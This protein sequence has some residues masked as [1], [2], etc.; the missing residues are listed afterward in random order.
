MSIYGTEYTRAVYLKKAGYNS[1]RWVIT[2]LLYQLYRENR[3]KFI[4]KVFKKKSAKP[5]MKYR[6][7]EIIT[8]ILKNL[9]PQ[10]TLEWGAGYSTLYFSQFAG[11]DAKWFSIEHHGDW[12]QRVKAMNTNLNMEIFYVE[13]DHFPWTDEFNDGSYSDLK[14]YIDFADGLGDF[15]FI[16]I[17]GRARKEALRKAFQLI[18]DDGVVVL[19]DANRHYYHEPF[20]LFNHQALFADKRGDGGGIWVGSK[21]REINSVLDLAL[22][23]KLWRIYNMFQKD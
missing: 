7:I 9:K 11:K 23:A 3:D 1:K 6:E 10:R 18:K 19:H 14:Q 5:L 2:A 8:E 20:K 22:Y 12:A 15:D 17:D 13:P 16:F 21:G 4:H